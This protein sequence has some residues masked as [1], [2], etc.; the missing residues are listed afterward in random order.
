MLFSLALIF[1]LG[2][3]VGGLLRR[4]HLPSLLGFLIIGIG[5]GP[6]GFNLIDASI[7]NI[8]SELREMA[9]IIILTRGAL[10]LNLK[11]LRTIGKPAIL[12]CFLPALF[13]IVAVVLLSMWL[14]NMPF[15][16]SI[17]LGSILGA[18]S[19]AVI[20]PKMLSMIEEKH[21]TAKGIP[22]LIIAG[23]SADDIVVVLIFTATLGV[24]LTG[25]FAFS[26]LIQVPIG[27]ILGALVGIVLGLA[28]VAFFKRVHMRDSM[29]VILLLSFSF[30]LMA[31]EDVLHDVVGFSGLISLIAMNLTIG[32]RYPVL[33]TRLSNKYTKLWIVA[34]MLLF[35][36]VGAVVNLNLFLPH[37]IKGLGLITGA[38]LI[39]FL[40][41]QASIGG[42]NLNRR[43]RLF[44]GISYLPKATV[45]AAIG[46]IPLT[47][48]LPYG[49]FI[50]SMAVFSILLT[51][52]IGAILMDVGGKFL[53][54][55]DNIEKLKDK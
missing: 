55:Y 14:F 11:E 41:V 54:S 15:L 27:M 37:F 42:M 40:G 24:A 50:L 30:L 1:I 22:Q 51:A 8:S 28:L 2:L 23:A 49:E 25:S 43:E 32:H 48:G 12:M 47:L 7:L 5:L 33:S 18:V 46:A 9:L 4:L 35:V 44:C 13:E 3:G 53:I 21:G 19:P 29:K 38:L 31:V 52:P 39:R 34:E 17:L 36:L 26:S 20:I 16:E 45:Q 6:Y 10:A